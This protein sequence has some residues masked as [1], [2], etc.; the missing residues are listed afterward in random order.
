MAT[1]VVRFLSMLTFSVFTAS[2]IEID[3]WVA[4][5]LSALDDGDAV[6]AWTSYSNR[7]VV[8]ASGF[9]PT[10]K[11]SVTPVGGAAVRFNRHW[12]VSSSSPFGGAT[13]FSIA[14]VFKASA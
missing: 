3:R 14:I 1:R 6:A 5:D 2:A 7:T 9:Q 8:G 12:M 13:A 4:E 10:F 11:K